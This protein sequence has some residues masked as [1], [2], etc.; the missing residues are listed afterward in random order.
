MVYIPTPI[1]INTTPSL[2]RAVKYILDD[3]KTLES[4]STENKFPVV[5]RDGK[6]VSQLI[7]GHL[8][9]DEYKAAEE[10]IMTKKLADKRLGRKETSDLVTGKGVLARHIIQSFS[11]D[12]QL[13][14]EE[15]HEIGR[16][17]MLEFT[18]GNYEF[19]IATHVDKQ[20]IHNH[21]ILNTTNA[22]TLKKFRWKKN[23]LQQLKLVSDR[24][25][26]LAG[27]KIIDRQPN[28][29]H[30]AYA[31]Y[32]KKNIFKLEI[33]SRLEFLLKHSTSV[34]DFKE[35][36]AALNLFVDLSGKN[37]K[38]RL[39][40][41]PQTRNTRDDILSKRGKYS[42]DSIEKWTS[43][44]SLVYSLS[45][46]KE[47]YDEFKK[48]K[49]TDFEMRLTIDS[50]QVKEET[51]T[52]IYLDVDYGVRNQGTVKIPYR[53]VDKLEDG[54]YELFIKKSD[55]FYFINPDHSE[56]NKYIKGATLIRQLAYNNGEYILTHNPQISKLDQLIK[57]FEFLSAHEVSSQEQFQDL[58]ERLHLQ[59][60]ETEATLEQLDDKII[61]LN[62]IS[63]A[64]SDY[65]SGNSTSSQAAKEI[66]A[67][68]HID[69]SSRSDLME[70][71]IIE[72]S[73]ERESLKAKFDEI[74]RDLTN[75]REVKDNVKMREEERNLSF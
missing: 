43:K 60:K 55:F 68:F 28:F 12:D 74:V 4:V 53:M 37:I 21:I 56:N 71:E 15:I 20:H 61:R 47:R 62:K 45:E 34:D 59:L 65:Q 70:K 41:Q 3:A 27:A 1:E 72:L 2:I 13:T 29:N 25:A 63:A 54:N 8:I 46:I 16:K 73:V 26:D 18:G 69:P 7:S 6:V 50:W 38:Y 52:G 51:Q 33:K 67:E 11:P 48:A 24:H 5:L 75:Y 9:S 57:E 31:A 58:S 44:N 19:V 22:D 10:F 14:P 17:T 64:L 66:L 36:A 39:L 23:T 32:R 35:K 49:A 42:L 40:D 30:T